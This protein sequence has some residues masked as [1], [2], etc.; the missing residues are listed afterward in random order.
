MKALRVSG[1]ILVLALLLAKPSGSARASTAL[2][3]RGTLAPV[4]ER[5]QANTCHVATNGDLDW[6]Q[7]QRDAQRTGYTPEVLGTEFQIAWR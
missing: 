5:T 7:V 4:S 6:P 3:T 2:G 1:L